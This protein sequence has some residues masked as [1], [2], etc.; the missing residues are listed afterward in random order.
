MGGSIP[1]RLPRLQRV[2][3]SLLRLPLAA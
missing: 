1:Q 2:L 3:N